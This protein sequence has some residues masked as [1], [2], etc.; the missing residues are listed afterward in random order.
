MVN[1]DKR[2]EE[3]AKNFQKVK[4]DMDKIFNK[5]M[6]DLGKKMGEKK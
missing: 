1:Q 6:N 5:A 3:A 2:L 4:E